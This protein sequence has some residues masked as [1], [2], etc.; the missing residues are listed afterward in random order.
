MIDEVKGVTPAP[1]P[2]IVSAS[3]PQADARSNDS[4]LDAYLKTCF[5]N[6]FHNSAKLGPSATAMPEMTS[7]AEST[8][9][10]SDSVVS[11]SDRSASSSMASSSWHFGPSCMIMVKSM[12]CVNW[13][14]ARTRSSRAARSRRAR[15]GSWLP[16]AARSLAARLPQEHSVASASFD[17][18]CVLNSPYA[19]LFVPQY[20]NNDTTL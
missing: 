6:V 17:G 20:F 16:V 5:S 2:V 18:R 3:T 11:M 4:P 13:T 7:I 8:I 15:I 9:S 14:D 10:Q 19:L 1:I 12:L